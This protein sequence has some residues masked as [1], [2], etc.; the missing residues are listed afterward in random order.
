MY[1][2]TYAP[3][4]EEKYNQTLIAVIERLLTSSKDKKYRSTFLMT[5]T[6]LCSTSTTEIRPHYVRSTAA[7]VVRILSDTEDTNAQAL[8]SCRNAL[9]HIQRI[10]K[11]VAIKTIIE[12][13]E[14]RLKSDSPF[15]FD[16]K[17][18]FILLGF[19]TPTDWTDSI[20]KGEAKSVEDSLNA[21]SINAKTMDSVEQERIEARNQWI[22]VKLALR[23]TSN[24]PSGVID[25][26]TSSSKKEE[27]AIKTVMF[28]NVDGLSKRIDEVLHILIRDKPSVMVLTEIKGDGTT[29]LRIGPEKDLRKTL[30]DLGYDCVSASTCAL[31]S[32]GPGNYGVMVLSRRTPDSIVLGLGETTNKDHE[33][34]SREGRVVTMRFKNPNIH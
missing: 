17:A 24:S 23:P 20:A 30:R 12:L 25:W 9:A 11:N 6:D 22:R 31:E 4:L 29:L 34:L 19:I 1:I 26:R 14:D 10:G 21:L 5:L 13:I 16:E 33:D 2:Q 18:R 28:W 8:K 7:A 32:I 27:K 3:R 15:K